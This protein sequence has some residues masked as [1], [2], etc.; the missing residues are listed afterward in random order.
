MK[1]LYIGQYSNGTTSKMRADTIADILSD[2]QFDVVD[3][4][5][6]FYE[7]SKLM[8]S[9]GFRFQKG[10][11]IKNINKYILNNLTSKYDF[12]W[13]DKA[14]FIKPQT[15]RILKTHT[16]KLIH[17]T[18]DAAFVINKSLLFQKSLPLYDFIITTKSFELDYYKNRA[19]INKIIFATQGFDKN[20]HKP[21]VSFENKKNAI[22]FIGRYEKNRANMIRLLLS[23]QINISVSG[24]KWKE[25]AKKHQNNKYFLWLGE[26]L[27]S[28]EYSKTISSYKISWGALSKLMPEKHTTRTFE[29]PACGTALITERNKETTKF[30]TNDEAIFY[31]TNEE[32][33]KK[34][35]YYLN[36]EEEL[37]LISEKGY[38][39]VIAKGYDYKSILRKT[40]I[41]TKII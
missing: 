30:F 4:N 40:L 32:F 1:F 10:Q 38:N 16:K 6:P 12:I 17:Y 27:Y 18:P 33:V 15:T 7:T 29:I 25:F 41:Q 14:I 11:L 35:K 21:I 31:S 39:K 23:E 37:K 24:N 20:T 13:V 3:T 5:I 9:L 26:G 34:I 2:W 28:N 19:D 36:N 22:L 8:R